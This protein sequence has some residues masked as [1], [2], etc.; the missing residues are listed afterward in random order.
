MLNILI[1]KYIYITC[2]YI[3]RKESQEV[4]KVEH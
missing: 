4:T 3:D 1:E 2:L